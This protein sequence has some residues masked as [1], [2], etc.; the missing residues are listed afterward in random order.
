MDDIFEIAES[1]KLQR[2]A[3]EHYKI[4]GCSFNF[5]I[6]PQLFSRDANAS[7]HSYSISPFS[8]D[9]RWPS[10]GRLTSFIDVSSEIGTTY[11]RRMHPIVSSWVS[12][13]VDR[14]VLVTGDPFLLMSRTFASTILTDKSCRELFAAMDLGFAPEMNFFD[15]V[16]ASPQ[17]QMK[18]Q[19]GHVYH[20]ND[21]SAAASALDI[22]SASFASDM[23]KRMYMRKMIGA[24]SAEFIQN[25]SEK[26]ASDSPIDK[27]FL[28]VTVNMTKVAGRETFPSLT[29]YILEC[30]LDV[31]CVAQDFLGKY[32]HSFF[33]KPD[34]IVKSEEFDGDISWSFSG[35]VLN[36]L[37]N[38]RII[39]YRKFTS[40]G[41]SL[42]F[43][44]DEVVSI[45]NNWS[46]FLKFDLKDICGEGDF[47]VSILPD[48]SLN[49][50]QIE[51][52][53]LGSNSRIA[54]VLTS[55]DEQEILDYPVAVERKK[56]IIHE[57]RQVNGTDIVLAS[58]NGFPSLLRTESR[59]VANGRC[60]TVMMAA[61]AED[62]DAW[63]EGYVGGGIVQLWKCDIIG[64]ARVETLSDKLDVE[65][66]PDS[67]VR[68]LSGATIG[69]WL[70]KP[71]GLWIFGIKG[72]RVCLATQFT[73]CEGIWRF[74]GWA[75]KNLKDL[76]TFSIRLGSVDKP[77]NS[78][79]PRRGGV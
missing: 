77:E 13:V 23:N 60:V 31:R 43:V 41:I 52:E 57:I 68:D 16:M 19:A 2:L 49:L 65:F 59:Y 15:T 37:W 78:R 47:I 40:D 74:S 72:M 48:I 79:F 50:G 53:W 28:A 70:A 69:R 42:V 61:S 67:S 30:L 38:S 20:R 27:Y 35:G 71:G 44:P 6:E 39:N 63:D 36:I 32:K 45:E 7:S 29:Q 21:S 10:F 46:I 25:F 58:V 54:A 17:Y 66:A 33:I 62:L 73:N 3:G 75:Q 12:S 55:F 56:G 14:H 76:V 34:G 11:T 51:G 64:R 9:M 24:K 4:M 5:S 1:D 22:P 18:N 8:G 26:I